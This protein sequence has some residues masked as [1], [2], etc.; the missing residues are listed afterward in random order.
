MHW[1]NGRAQILRSCLGLIPLDVFLAHPGAILVFQKKSNH[2]INQSGAENP[3]D[4][5]LDP[6]PI[7]HTHQRHQEANDPANPRWKI[8]SSEWSRV[9]QRIEQGETLRQI[10][11][12]YGESY[13]AVRRVVRAERGYTGKENL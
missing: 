3:F 10:A 11:R 6:P 5:V 12:D 8:P 2:T 7:I 4:Q 9:L 13:E 1:R